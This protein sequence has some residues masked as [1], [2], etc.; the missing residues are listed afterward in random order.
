[1]IKDNCNSTLY[2]KV[3]RK[4]FYPKTVA[5]IGVSNPSTSNV[6]KFIEDNV[7][8]IL[9]E[10]NPKPIKQIKDR[11]GTKPNVT[12]YEVAICDFDGTVELCERASSTFISSLPSSPA[13]V[14]DSCN[15]ADSEK[16]TAQAIKFSTIDNGDIDL[17]S[18]DVEGSEWFVIKN[19]ISRPSIISIETHGGL[20]INPYAKELTTW[21]VDNGYILWFKDKSDSVY[22][23][24]DSINI[25]FLDSI[26]LYLTDLLLILKSL[27][28]QISKKLK[29]ARLK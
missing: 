16:F 28:K 7:K 2:D 13:L 22:I 17:I 27:K 4:M 9:V 11:W 29:Q 23:L 12:L 19:M 25:T 26:R 6:Y 1:M 21:M 24:K 20:Y 15:I 5:E 3:K 8:T 10:P 18:I 14:N